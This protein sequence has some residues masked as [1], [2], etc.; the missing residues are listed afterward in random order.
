MPP[1]NL[2]QIPHSPR[3][4]IT[5]LHRPA[6]Q[7]CK[8][9]LDGPSSISVSP[10]GLA[11]L[12]SPP[13]PDWLENRSVSLLLLIVGLAPSLRPKP[14][15][16]HLT[17][18]YPL[19]SPPHPL[20]LP[21]T[22]LPTSPPYLFPPHTLHLTCPQ[23]L[24]APR[25]PPTHLP[26]S[27]SRLGRG[28]YSPS[29]VGHLSLPSP[30]PELVLGGHRGEQRLC[31]T[32]LRGASA[33]VAHGPARRLCHLC[34]QVQVTVLRLGHGPALS[35]CSTHS[36]APRPRRSHPAGATTNTEAETPSEEP[37][38]AKCGPWHLPSGPPP[39]EAEP[40]HRRGP[41]AG[42][43]HSAHSCPGGWL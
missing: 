42:G 6:H 35:V 23:Q 2:P 7:G 21:S 36:T 12:S 5:L 41:P 9:G 33:F 4:T 28:M 43:P 13:L 10:W 40:G 37:A 15:S 20:P 14:V 16:P 25:I 30:H 24:Q 18:P 8:T 19:L 34:V 3:C 27:P 31:P 29:F 11:P 32:P 39:R 22:P 38:Q 1:I 17:P 26:K